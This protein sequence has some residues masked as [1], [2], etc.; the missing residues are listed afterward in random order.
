MIVAAIPAFNEEGM[1][2]KIVVRA[3]KH[4]DKVVVVDD[5]S[6]DDTGIIA[7]QLGAYVVK[8]EGNLGY[9]AALRSC[10]GTARDLNADILVI[11]DAD[12]QH[13]PDVIPALVQPIAN[14]EADIV[15]GSRFLGKKSDM[16]PYRVAGLRLLNAAT[17]AAT[18]QKIRDTQSGFRA[19]SK[20]ALWALELYETTMGA[21]SELTIKSTS[22]GLRVLE[23]PIKI[24]YNGLDTS[25]QNALSHGAAV[26]SSILVTAAERH[27]IALFTLP[28]AALVAVAVGGLS[29]V[30]Q[31]WLTLNL[32][33]LG[34]AIAFTSMLVVGM[35]AAFV[36]IVLFA[37]SRVS[38][39]L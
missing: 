35:F 23:I 7:N 3:S 8:H 4:V 11:L 33:A 39:R 27:P 31:R 28:G 25:S 30:L 16:P 1:I 9:G 24:A 6:T 37:I 34:P 2:A 32:F 29:W 26:L 15:I 21:S 5:G 20:K 18:K 12:G 10:I 17:N 14:S 38:R 13:N 19:Y 22:A 36:G